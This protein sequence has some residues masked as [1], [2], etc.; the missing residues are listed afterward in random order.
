MTQPRYIIDGHVHITNRAYWEGLDPWLPQE[1]G[2]DF[3]RAAQAGVNVIIENVAPYGFCN[4]NQTTRQVVRLIEA[5]HRMIESHPDQAGLALTAGQ[6][7]DIAASGRIAVFLGIEG[8]F[9]HDG[10]PDVLRALHRLGVRAV[11][12]STQTCFNA[13]AD[14]ELGKPTWHGINAKGRQLVRT[15]NELGVLIDVTHATPA[16]QAQIIDCSEAPVVAS[17]CALAAVSGDGAGGIGLLSDEILQAIAAKGGMVGIIGAGARL[18]RRFGEWQ[19]AHPDDAARVSA[20]LTGLVDVIVPLRREPLDHGEF[21]A[22][23][24]SELR[25]RHR[26]AFELPPQTAVDVSELL[27]TA[28]EWAAHVAHAAGVAGP[29]HV[30]IGLD[31]ASG[32]YPCVPVNAS[33]YPDLVTAAERIVGPAELGNV[34]GENWLR[35]LHTVLGG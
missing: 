21:N 35:V 17:H 15:M 16:A 14:A 7:R 2:F 30:G 27:P 12:F 33:G 31:M 10:D 32:H 24:D 4:Y 20:A 8:G 22:W 5:F 13:Y 23:L 6:A 19:R 34:A 26:A 25:A 9:D 1:Y 28:D 29:A 3:S 18:T 11:Q